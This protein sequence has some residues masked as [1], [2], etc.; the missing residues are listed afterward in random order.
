[1]FKYQDSIG[2]NSGEVR[3]STAFF[4]QPN[5][6]RDLS[7]LK[8]KNVP[9]SKLEKDFRANTQ[10]HIKLNSINISKYQQS[11]RMMRNLGEADKAFL[12]PKKLEERIA[13]YKRNNLEAKVKL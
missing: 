3:V 4:M 11:E 2:N 9:Q 13:A 5:A 12:R 10:D 1:M 6:N 8:A 7:E